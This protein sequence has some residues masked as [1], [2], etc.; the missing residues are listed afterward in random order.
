MKGSRIII[1]CLLRENVDTLFGYIGGAVIP[2][3]DA[4]YHYQDRIRLIRPHHEQAA[5]HAADGYARSTGRTGVVMVTSGPGATNTVTG[6][7][8]AGMDSVP[9]V[10]IT[11]QI[12]STH[13]GTD[14]FQEADITGITMPIT[15]AS[16]LVRDIAELGPTLAAA[17]AIAR[18]DRP[19]PVLVDIPSD[20]QKMEF[21][22]APAPDVRL[23]LRR[24]PSEP[25]RPDLL[26]EAWEQLRRSRRPLAI[27]GGGVMFSEA[28]QRINPFIERHRLPAVHTLMG[29]G[30]DPADPDLYLGG[31]GMHGTPWGNYALQRADLVLAMGTRFSDR[32]IGNSR[33]FAPRARLIQVDVDPAEIGK[34]LAVDVPIVG[35]AGDFMQAMTGMVGGVRDH[36]DWLEEINAVRRQH[37]FSSPDNG[38]LKPQPLIRLLCRHFPAGTIVASD[39]GQNQMWVAQH[40]R[41]RRERCFLSSGGLGTMGFALPAAIGAR[42]GNPGREVLMIAGDGGFQM[43]IQEL[44]TIRKYG[45]GVKMVILDNGCL[46]MVRQWQ[47]V[48]YGRRYIGTDM[49]GNP[50]FARIGRA[51][52]IRART[53]STPQEAEPAVVELV[54]AKGP[55]LLHA[56]IDPEENVLP[57]VPPGKSLSQMIMEI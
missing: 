4:L 11:G 49:A 56:R 18:S 12:A 16:F 28:A 50:D 25:L 57:M 20:I 47:E 44:A 34:V 7:A 21:I 5:V 27:I 22:D 8:T 51:Y 55:M 9:L 45:L 30:I 39:V 29:H 54:R 23:P 24:K 14:A 48:L 36:A 46:G 32:I 17:F 41:F 33:R 35:R 42:I 26:A 15:K 38:R 13:I 19:G 40:F 10:I 53:I 37:A 43:N 2:L 3:F 1:E 52:G 6:I 31:I